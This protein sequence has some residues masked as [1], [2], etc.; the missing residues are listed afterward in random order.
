MGV[1]ANE[2]NTQNSMNNWQI[3]GQGSLPQCR[4]TGPLKR[5]KAFPDDV[6]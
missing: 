3:L 6:R 4:A 2:Q 5:Y 1:S